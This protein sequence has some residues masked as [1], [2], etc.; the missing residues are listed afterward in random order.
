MSQNYNTC[1][2][3]PEIMYFREVCENI[4]RK[5]SLRSWCKTCEL[6]QDKPKTSD[7]QPG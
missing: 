1:P 5:G 7:Q 6:F 2:K 3:D 4:F